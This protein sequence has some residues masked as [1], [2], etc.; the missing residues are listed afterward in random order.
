MKMKKSKK[1]IS[2]ISLVIA[3][4]GL[5]IGKGE[6]NV[7]AD[8]YFPPLGKAQDPPTKPP[9]S[10]KAK[11]KK[12]K[13]TTKKKTK[14]T[15]KKTKLKKKKVNKKTK[16]KKAKTKKKKVVKKRKNKVNILRK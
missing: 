12:T 16:K 1:I 9:V 2:L 6:E 3:G 7:K 4:V 15:T 5:F 11:A 14:K 10:H 13:K 8:E